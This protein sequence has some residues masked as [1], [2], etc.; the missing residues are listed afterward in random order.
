MARLFYVQQ[1]H[2]DDCGPAALKMLFANVFF[3]ERYLFVEEKWP[4]PMSLRHMVEIANEYGVTLKGYKLHHPSSIRGIHQPFI[5]LRYLPTPHFVCVFPLPKN[6]YRIFDPQSPPSLVREDY[7]ARLFSGVIVLLKHVHTPPK[8]RFQNF[9]KGF[10]PRF[11]PVS[12]GAMLT[13]MVG[14]WNFADS[15]IGWIAIMVGVVFVLGWLTVVIKTIFTLD[16]AMINQYHRLIMDADQYRRYHQWKQGYLILP[17]Q[18]FYR[19]L[20]LLTM[21]L[22][23]LLASPGFFIPLIAHTCLKG[24]YRQL[25]VAKKNLTMKSLETEETSLQ[26][27]LNRG[28]PLVNISHHVNRLLT[29][30]L[31]EHV[32]M[33]LLALTL[34]GGYYLAVPYQDFLTL[35]TGITLLMLFSHHALALLDHHQQKQAWRQLGYTFLNQPDYAKI[36]K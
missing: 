2:Q 33:T 4:R 18:Q 14:I 19:W 3:D 35:V 9:P 25:V 27:P 11:F 7:F 12:L 10:A 21:S 20:L 26:Y 32:L 15:L 36:K 29:F 13:V 5:A 17:L 8:Q 24:G 1:L 28:Q 16:Q 6:R 22:Y 31:T 30:Y 23:L 34:M